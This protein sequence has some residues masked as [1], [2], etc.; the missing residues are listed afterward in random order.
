ML[1]IA[2]C[3]E[4]KCIGNKVRPVL[5]KYLSLQG[6]ASEVNSFRSGNDFLEQ[7][8]KLANY[9][10]V[11]LD[12]KKDDPDGIET[13]RKIREIGKELF[14]V[15]TSG[16]EYPGF[17]TEG[18]KLDV[19]RYILKN[20]E[21]FI[22]DVYECMDAIIGKLNGLSPWQ[23]YFFNEGYRAVALERLLYIES[24]LHKLEF[25][26]LEDGWKIY[27][28]YDTLNK[29]EGSLINNGFVRIHQSFLV[30]MRYMQAVSRYKV[31]M[32]NGIQFTIP[33][34]RYNRVEGQF[35]AYKGGVRRIDDIRM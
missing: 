23:G 4:E 1:K 5:H 18:Y 16:S 26:V 34:A 20:G 13:A 29:I 14:V 15:L 19:F 3:E 6:I 25:H 2:I 11:F 28:L 21:D 27:S 33:R 32:D 24:H 10:M 17:M 12:I 22:A 8:T 30:N 31:Q 35:V 7:G 9:K